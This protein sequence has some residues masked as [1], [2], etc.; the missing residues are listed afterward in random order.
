MSDPDD[1]W[2][3]PSLP[4]RRRAFASADRAGL[5]RAE[6]IELAEMVLK[7]DVT[8]WDALTEKD[9]GRLCDALDGWAFVTAL[10]ALRPSPH[11]PIEAGVVEPEDAALSE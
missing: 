4:Q 10:H 11:A 8:T 5:T 6:R 7:K 2:G 1:P 9:F 3:E